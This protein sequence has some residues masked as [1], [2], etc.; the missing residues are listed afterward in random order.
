[1]TKPLTLSLEQNMS[2]KNQ[3]LNK[4][5]N[6]CNALFITRGCDSYLER[7]EENGGEGGGGASWARGLK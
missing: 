7:V 2:F 3:N 1:M 4:I 5:P 6:T